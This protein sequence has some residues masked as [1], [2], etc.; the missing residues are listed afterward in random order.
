MRLSA[1]DAAAVMV[2]IE[3][4]NDDG[5]LADPLEEI[6]AQ[7]RRRW[8]ADDADSARSWSTACAARCS[9]LQSMEPTGVGARNLAECL[10]LQLRA[11]PRSEAQ[12]VAIIDLQAATSS[13]W[14][15]AT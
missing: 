2:L 14:R 9:W 5:Y 4:L 12:T 7:L 6:A 10:T 15:G 8:T 1:D 11:L 13:C 3:S